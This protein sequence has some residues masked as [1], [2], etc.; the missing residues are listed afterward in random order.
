[1][2]RRAAVGALEPELKDEPMR[3]LTIPLVL[4]LLLSL[5]GC[6]GAPKAPMCDES[7]YRSLNPAHYDPVKD[8]TRADVPILFPQS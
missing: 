3:I 4:L 7:A 8:S 2:S 5:G 1:M 6:A